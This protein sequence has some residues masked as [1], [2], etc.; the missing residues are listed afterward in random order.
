[1]A[2]GEAG[3]SA[4]QVR[5]LEQWLED[6]RERATRPPPLGA[7]ER[8]DREVEV[9]EWLGTHGVERPWEVAAQLVDV[10]YTREELAEFAG[11]FDAGV[12]A[13]ALA[14]LGAAASAGALVEQ[15]AHGAGRISEL[16]Q[17]LKAYS[18]MDQAPA[19]LVNV[20]EGLDSTLVML[21]SKLRQITV[22][23]T[24]APD[25][26]PLPAH[27]GE[28]NQVWTN[29]LDNAA[30]VLAGAAGG[31]TITIETRRD[32]EWVVVGIEDNGPGIPEEI[33]A[34]VFDPFFT[35]KEPGKGAGLGLNI[36]H[37]IV[38]QRH[39]GKLTVTSRPGM[40]RFEAW[41]P[42]SARVDQAEQ[43]EDGETQT[44]RG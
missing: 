2:L 20:H 43:A 39:G 33:Q 38:A 32:G 15:V 17:A 8:S 24:Y 26:P 12:A 11:A 18:Y 40:T 25:L 5:L 37:T 19:Q 3:L 31:G 44:S 23:R 16:V 41:L 4:T 1:M 14:W 30:E 10:G 6:L 29:I 21:R 9:E 28:L 27:G 36:S 7:L 35:T 22:R 34:R 42:L 13:P